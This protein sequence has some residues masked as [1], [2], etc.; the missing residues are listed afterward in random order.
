MAADAGSAGPLRIEREGAVETLIINDA[1]R[2]RMSLAF[3]DALEAEIERV[4]DDAGVRAIVVRGAVR[5]KELAHAELATEWA[6]RLREASGT[7][8]SEAL[9]LAARA[10]HIERWTVPRA[11][12]PATSSG[13]PAST[14]ST[15]PGRRSSSRRRATTRPPSRP[16]RR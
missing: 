13:A 12:Y 4:A 3:M 5:P 7:P 16:P 11:S 15:P 10:H 9:L 1:P 2:N 8:P 14:S 6:W